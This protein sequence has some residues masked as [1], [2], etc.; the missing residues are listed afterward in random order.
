M[1]HMLTYHIEVDGAGNV[2]NVINVQPSKSNDLVQPGGESSDCGQAAESS[3]KKVSDDCKSPSL[4][5]DGV[6]D[7]DEELA[8]SVRKEVA[9]TGNTMVEF[10]GANKDIE[11]EDFGPEM[12]RQHNPSLLEASD[13]SDALTSGSVTGAK[14]KCL[15]N[16]DPAWESAATDSSLKSKAPAGTD[17]RLAHKETNI[18]D[19]EEKAVSQKSS[20]S[21]I[22]VTN[23]QKDQKDF[24]LIRFCR[25]VVEGIVGS[26]STLLC[27]KRRK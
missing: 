25:V 19:G 20:V 5:L 15:V 27:G 21:T 16:D 24:W 11:A 9:L 18:Q 12:V 1:Q 14:Q 7:S 8:R 23:G 10:H 13:A 2:N 26:M 17:R 6:E 4:G 3:S 22:S